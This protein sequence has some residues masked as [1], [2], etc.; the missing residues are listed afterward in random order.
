MT[1]MGLISVVATLFAPETYHKDIDEDE[2]EEQELV[3]EQ[4]FDRERFRE[5]AGTR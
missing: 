3:R 5:P 1:G 4:R 2:H